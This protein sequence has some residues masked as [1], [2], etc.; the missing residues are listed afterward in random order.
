MK[1]STRVLVALGAALAIGIALAGGGNLA[2]L[3]LVDAI[4]PLGTLWVNGI[5]MTVIP[6]IVSLLIVGVAS[7]TDVK[8]VGRL[9][10]RTLLVFVAM[11]AALAVVMIPLTLAV[12]GLLGARGADAP[13]LPAGSAEAAQLLAS[14]PKQSIAGW[15]VSLVPSNP[16]AAAAGGSLLPVIVFTLLFGLAV[17]RAAPAARETL[18]RFF[19]AVSEA[20]LILVRW[21]ILA[22][23]VGVFALVL[24]LAAR[25]GGAIAGAIGFYIVAY[26]LLS[27]AGILFAYPMVAVFGGISMKRF[28]LAALPAQL[29]A[30]TSSS[31][32]ASLPA[33]VESARRGLGLPQRVSGFVLPLAVSTFHFAGPVTWTVGAVFVGWFYGR[34]LGPRELTIVAFASVFLTSAAPGVPRGGFIMLAPLFSEIGLPVEGIGILIALDV[35]PDTFATALNVT[36]DLA[37][38]ALVAKHEP[39]GGGPEEPADTTLTVEGH[40]STQAR[41]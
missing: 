9:G 20:M 16:I 31:S 26:S 10:A 34:P 35:I 3:G 23:P 36:G 29:I 28:A 30:F 41:Q 32:V 40:L 8:A 6:L 19:Q 5:R 1:E 27:V 7:A 38:A 24:P 21:V 33:L 11:L 25:A 22:A 15:L 39:A 17:A 37:A 18:V 12:F 13:P 4:A 14:D 2:L